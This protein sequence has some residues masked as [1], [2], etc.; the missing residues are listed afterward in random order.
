MRYFFALGAAANSAAVSFFTVPS[1]SRTYPP[2]VGGVLLVGDHA[3]LAGG[4]RVAPEVDD[5]LAGQRLAEAAGL[6]AS[7]PAIAATEAGGRPFACW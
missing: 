3:G 5:L 7:A 1:W 2:A 4:D 6:A